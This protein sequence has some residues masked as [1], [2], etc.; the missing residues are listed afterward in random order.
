MIHNFGMVSKVIR[1]FRVDFFRYK[2]L[3][4][5]CRRFLL[6]YE[7]FFDPFKK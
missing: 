2:R 5:R 6:L 3:K 7:M 1:E 4:R